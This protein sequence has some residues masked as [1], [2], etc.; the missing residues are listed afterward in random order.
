[1]EAVYHT[2][3]KVLIRLTGKQEKTSWGYIYNECKCKSF[4][5]LQEAE[6]Y[7]H[8]YFKGRYKLRAD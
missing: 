2:R 7:L 8:T 3:A 1:M 4:K 6:N 5:T